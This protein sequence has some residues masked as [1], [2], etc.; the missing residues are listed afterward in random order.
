M[1]PLGAGVACALRR[2]PV[3][4][5]GAVV[6]RDLDGEPLDLDRRFGL[7]DDPEELAHFLAEAGFLH[8][9]DVFDPSEMAAIEA[10]IDQSI[11]AARDADPEYWWCTDADGTQVA[12]RS[13]NF[14]EKSA[15]VRATLADERSLAS[16]ISPETAI[17][18]RPN[19]KGW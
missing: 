18:P 9:H 4:E 2:R 17:G 15:A 13:L 1:D 5:P 16:P 8:L 6:M 19:A 12:V 14:Q 11:A 7:D 3:H 10:D